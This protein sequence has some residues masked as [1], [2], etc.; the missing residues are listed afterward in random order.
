M[1]TTLEGFADFL[2]MHEASN[3][4]YSTI[5]CAFMGDLRFNMARS[6]IMMAAL[7]GSDPRLGGPADLAPPDDVLEAASEIAERTGPT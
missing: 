6:H 7:M 2:T 3:K 5:S 4:P 1:A